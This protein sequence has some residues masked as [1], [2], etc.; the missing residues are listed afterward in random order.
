LNS[1]V[2]AGSAELFFNSAGLDFPNVIALCVPLLRVGRPIV[3]RSGLTGEKAA[4]SKWVA[5]VS[6]VLTVGSSP[7]P[8]KL[9]ASNRPL[10][11]QYPKPVM[12]E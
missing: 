6:V 8:Q 1:G 12:S 5:T 11:S 3:G 4:E 7:Q 9:S 2:E 10:R